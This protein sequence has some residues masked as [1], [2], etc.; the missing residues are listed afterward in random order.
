MSKL[1]SIQQAIDSMTHRFQPDKTKGVDAKYQWLISGDGGKDFCVHV[2]DGE[3]SIIEDKVE[4]PTV[5][6]KITIEDY[7]RL[8]NGELKGM[9]AILTRKLIVHGNIFLANKM[10]L[11]FK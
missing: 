11:F 7:L 9:T 6:Y 8:V 2:N 4:Q 5:T 3:F 1:I 10:D